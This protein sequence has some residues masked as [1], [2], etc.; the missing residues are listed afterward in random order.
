MNHIFV[1]WFSKF[2][3]YIMYSIPEFT[4]FL[5]LSKCLL[6]HTVFEFYCHNELG[7]SQH[8]MGFQEQNSN[9]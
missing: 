6:K 2:D 5:L 9:L 1:V 4:K 8:E 7:L 3:L